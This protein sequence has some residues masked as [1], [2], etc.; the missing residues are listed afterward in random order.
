MLYY[1]GTTRGGITTLQPHASPY[2]TY[3]Q[4]YVYLSSNR[5]IATFYIWNRPYMWHT[6][7]FRE[8]GL[9]VYTESFPDSLRAFYAGVG[10]YVYACETDAAL[11]NPTGIRCAAICEQPVPVIACESVEDAYERFLRYEEEGL[12]MVHRYDTLSEEQ[13]AS[14][15]RMVM[16]AIGRLNLLA[17]E[18]PLSGFVRETFSREWR[19]AGEIRPI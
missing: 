11:P 17:G 10:G 12:L 13:R 4:P 5:T 14:N 6:F 1:H 8:D 15:P 7:G 16:G 18:H 19:E 2:S 9:P 3:K